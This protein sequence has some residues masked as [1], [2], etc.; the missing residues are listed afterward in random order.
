MILRNAQADGSQ[1][2]DTVVVDA[3]DRTLQRTPCRRVL[4]LED[5]AW[6]AIELERLLEELGCEVCT[7]VNTAPAAIVAAAIHQPDFVLLDLRCSGARE[8]ASQICCDHAIP[9][10]CREDIVKPCASTWFKEELRRALL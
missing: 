9:T 4:V 3:G 2:A 1:A 7:I 5:D 6:L 10:I 8:A